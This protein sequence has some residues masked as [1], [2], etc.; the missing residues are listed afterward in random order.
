[1]NTPPFSFHN[2]RTARGAQD[3]V[4]ILEEGPAE[5]WSDHVNDGGSEGKPRNDFASWAEHGLREK[6][7]AE[8]LREAKSREE[9]IETIRKWLEPSIARQASFHGHKAT[10]FFIGL[11]IGIAIGVVIT[12][13]VMLL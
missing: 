4:I 8:R 5:L 9:G 11:A 13:L 3:L 7:L 6:A 12:Q 10:D 2:G 1:M